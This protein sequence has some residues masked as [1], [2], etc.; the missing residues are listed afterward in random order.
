[1]YETSISDDAV[2]CEYNGSTILVPK[3]IFLMTVFRMENADKL[4]VRYKEGAK[5][6]SISERQF[7]KIAHESGA[8]SKLEKIALVSIS[9]VQEYLDDRRL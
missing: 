9:K 4:Y 8:V 6:F 1:M 5:M 3:K 7:N 2:R